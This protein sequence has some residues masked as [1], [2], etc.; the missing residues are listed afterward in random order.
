[1]IQVNVSWELKLAQQS[2]GLWMMWCCDTK[3][4]VR[5]QVIVLGLNSY[6]HQAPDDSLEVQS[7]PEP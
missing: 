7:G 4:I 6:S 3:L 5:P 1:M 2:V